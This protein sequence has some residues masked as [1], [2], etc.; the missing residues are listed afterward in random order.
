MFTY[1]I[2]FRTVINRNRDVVGEAYARALGAKRKMATRKMI[3]RNRNIF[4]TIERE[5][6]LT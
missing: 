4:A 3:F 6:L 5:N 2:V 1:R